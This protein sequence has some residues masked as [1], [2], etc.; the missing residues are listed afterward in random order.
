MKAYDFY[1]ILFIVATQDND[2]TIESF[3]KMWNA[4]QQAEI[5]GE[6]AYN[7]G[8]AGGNVTAGFIECAAAYLEDWESE[9]RAGLEDG[10]HAEPD[11][12]G[13]HCSAGCFEEAQRVP[14]EIA[15]LD[16]DGKITEV[17]VGWLARF[18][19]DEFEQS[20]EIVEIK[21]RGSTVF[22]VLENGAGFEGQNLE[23]EIRTL[24]SLRDCWITANG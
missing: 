1:K 19:D 22:L 7:V 8:F 24:I 13:E 11:H 17:K 20:G 4:G 12:D 2:E 9:Y 23:G 10:G 15:G 14:G 21:T 18:Y 3:E 16:Y 5:I 6:G